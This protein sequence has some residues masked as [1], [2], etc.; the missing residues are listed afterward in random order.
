MTLTQ[1]N[2][3]HRA[4][5]ADAGLLELDAAFDRTDLT[6]VKDLLVVRQTLKLTTPQGTTYYLKRYHQPPR[7]RF[8]DQLGAR[9]FLSPASREY[10]VLQRLADLGLPAPCPAACLE[11]MAGRRVNRA[12][13][14]TL[15]LPPAVSLES[16][17]HPH[18]PAAAVARDLACR[19]GRMT[20][21]M[22]EGGVNHRDFYFAH[23]Q[24]GEEGTLYITDLNRADLRRRVGRRWRVKDLAALLHSA[25]P[26]VRR[27]DLARFARAYLGGA[28]RPHRR[29]LRAVMRKASRMRAHTLKRIAQGHPNY[30][31]AG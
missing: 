6:M 28:L 20:R 14:L 26:L 19:L 3:D 2:E 5:L 16:L 17:F 25:P 11:E 30:H 29:F 7:D 8:L 22:H 18:R 9:R 10:A 23:L 1:V 13:L 24:V 4:A 27:T 21:T 31:V 12:V 15:S